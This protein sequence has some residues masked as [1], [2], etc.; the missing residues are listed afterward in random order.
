M[1]EREREPARSSEHDKF[2]LDWR[3]GEA[4]SLDV[5]TRAGAG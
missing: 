1:R 2:S 5:G 3:C 4:S